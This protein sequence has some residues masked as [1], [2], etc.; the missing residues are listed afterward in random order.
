MRAMFYGYVE[1]FFRPAVP[2]MRSLPTL[3]FSLRPG[4]LERVGHS[5][6][7]LQAH[8]MVEKLEPENLLFFPSSRLAE[9]SFRSLLTGRFFPS[10]RYF[11]RYIPPCGFP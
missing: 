10:N 7:I 11:Y 3:L 8:C 6:Q 5:R 1:D 2:N 4:L 9:L